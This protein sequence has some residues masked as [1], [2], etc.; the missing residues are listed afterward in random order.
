LP[1]SAVILA[2]VKRFFRS[3]LL[4]PLL[5]CFARAQE[6]HWGEPVNGVCLGLS[7]PVSAITAAQSPRFIVV[8]KNVSSRPITIPS[9]DTFVLKANPDSDDYHELPLAPLV[10]D[11][12]SSQARGF[13]DFSS[14]GPGGK[15]VNLSPPHV[16][17]L[18]PGQMLTWDVNSLDQTLG[19]GVL[20]AAGPAI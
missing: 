14:F 1:S 20:P 6:I 5:L 2:P 19:P 12:Q 13:S 10:R 15:P 18:A 8:A 9:P 16:Q 7:S 3:A 17:T 11:T 4:L